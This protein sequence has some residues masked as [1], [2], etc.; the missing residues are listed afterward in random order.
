MFFRFKVK[1]VGLLEEFG[2]A[3]ADI[4]GVQQLAT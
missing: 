4:D 3:R 2:C 1:A